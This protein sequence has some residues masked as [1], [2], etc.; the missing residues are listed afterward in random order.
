MNILTPR[1]TTDGTK[2]IVSTD[3]I[4][5]SKKETL[6]FKIDKKYQEYLLLERADAFL[7]GLLLYAMANGE[8]IHLDCPVSEKLYY[9]LVNYLIPALILTNPKLR[10][11]KIIP[12]KLENTSVNIG[13]AV[14]T[15]FSGGVDSFCTIYD[16]LINPACPE[17]YRLTHLAF[18]NVGSHG[19]LGG[20]SARN[21]FHKRLGILNMFP[22]ECGLEYIVIDSNIS[23]ILQMSFITTAA[24]RSMAPVLLLQK[25]FRVYYF[26]SAY[27]MDDFQMLDDNDGRYGILTLALLSTESLDLY[28]SGCQ[29]TRVEKTAMISN[30]EPS[31]RYLN[32]CVC[33][34]GNCSV[35]FKCMRTLLTFDVLGTIERYSN[36]FDLEKYKA[37]KASYISHILANKHN[38]L[39]KE[40]YQAMIKNGYHIPFMSRLH[41]IKSLCES[42]LRK[43]AGRIYR[44]IIRR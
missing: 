19:E 24:I 33:D 44:Q 8:D 2:I 30:Y 27:R 42:P 6:W 35:C 36:I 14:G 3:Y 1:C 22:S 16:H 10:P 25:L 37:H 4:F 13:K 28:S 31:W 15:G 40:I 12:S 11:I 18:F 39:D 26:S 29:Y 38:D 32:V 23:E 43:I 7:V 34:G 9:N 17:H 5:H 41:L 21:L 20:E